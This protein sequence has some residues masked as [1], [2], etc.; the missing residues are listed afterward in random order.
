MQKRV[1]LFLGALFC[2]AA[3]CGCA[4]S[5]SGGP[6]AFSAPPSA[7]SAASRPLP[8]PYFEDE[9][10]GN[11]QYITAKFCK[12]YCVSIKGS[13]ADSPLSKQRSLPMA[14]AL[15]IMVSRSMPGEFVPGFET[16]HPISELEKGSVILEALSTA[17]PL[18]D[19][20]ESE[21]E[22]PCELPWVKVVL[23][24]PAH[25]AA[26]NKNGPA[27]EEW[28]ILV[29]PCPEHPEDLFVS[30]IFQD[31][32]ELKYNISVFYGY[33]AWFQTE[34]GLLAISWRV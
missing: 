18:L 32:G 30:T 22:A 15:E 31:E 20:T 23:E 26:S 8:T 7:L 19:P 34:L 29:Y 4:A 1:K 10:N 9:V 16:P 25:S 27:T 11:V 2:G 3:L 33:G 6:A 12:D 17:A 5:G 14:P 21:L 13:P 24:R 28:N